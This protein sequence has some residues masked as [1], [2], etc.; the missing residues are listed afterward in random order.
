MNQF[1]RPTKSKDI[2]RSWRLV[3]VKGQILGRASTHIAGLLM[4]KSKPY[5][6]RNMD[7]G[8]YVVVVNAKQVGVTGK[9]ET[10]KKYRRH[11]GYPGGFKEESLADLRSRKPGEIIYHAVSGMLPQNK[12]RDRM[13]TRLFVFEG[14]EQPYEDKFKIQKSKVKSSS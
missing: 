4:G 7:T 12:L 9:K 13:L 8:D 2:K 11:S 1:T 10:L 5:F 3:D 14:E 6:A